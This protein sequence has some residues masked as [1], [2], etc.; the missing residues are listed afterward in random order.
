MSLQEERSAQRLADLFGA[1]GHTRRVVIMS[2]LLE[3]EKSVGELCGCERLQP[4][5]QPNISQH[6]AT[7]RNAGLVKERREGTRVFYRIA[8]PHLR[9][10]VKSGLLLTEENRLLAA[11]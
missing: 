9:S 2:C 8:S 4:N 7:L 6:L 1:L 5:S 11:A 10:L 3:G